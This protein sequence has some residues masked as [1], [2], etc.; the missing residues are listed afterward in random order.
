MKRDVVRR[1]SSPQPYQD[2]QPGL[3][4]H[5]MAD[6]N[7]GKEIFPLLASRSEAPGAWTTMMHRKPPG[8]R[9]D[10]GDKLPWRAGSAGRWDLSQR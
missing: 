8:R 6:H 5:R 7:V 2:P 10:M 4:A 9:D 1:L 3:R